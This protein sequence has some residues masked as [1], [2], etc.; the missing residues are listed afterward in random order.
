[1]ERKGNDRPFTQKTKILREGGL[2]GTPEAD[3]KSKAAKKPERNLT[4]ASLEEYLAN[5]GA[6]LSYAQKQL[7]EIA[8]KRNLSRQDRAEVKSYVDER[9]RRYPHKVPSARGQK[10]FIRK[11]IRNGIYDL[12]KSNRPYVVLVLAEGVVLTDLIVK[13]KARDLKP[14]RKGYWAHHNA[15]E[16]R[17]DTAVLDHLSE[18]DRVLLIIPIFSGY[19][20]PMLSTGGNESGVQNPIET[21]ASVNPWHDV[22]MRLDEE[23]AREQLAQEN[24]LGAEAS[25]QHFGYGRSYRELSKQG[26]Y[27]DTHYRNRLDQYQRDF[28]RQFPELRSY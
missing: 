18:D 7:F 11:L 24:P 12:H 20:N 22:Q 4:Y 27:S 3:T 6:I 23:T 9:C 2:S 28:R 5:R 1:M 26:E 8:S 15:F 13:S 21:V 16:G 25:L 19:L 17:I 14:V 10:A